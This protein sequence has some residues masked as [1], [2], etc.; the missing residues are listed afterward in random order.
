MNSWKECLKKADKNHPRS[1]D[2]IPELGIVPLPQFTFMQVT[3][4]ETTDFIK[5]HYS[6]TLDDL[7]HGHLYYANQCNSKGKLTANQ[8][9][10][11]LNEHLTYCIYNNILHKH[12]TQL[13]QEGLKQPSSIHPMDHLCIFGVFGSTAHDYMQHYFSHNEKATPFGSGYILALEDNRYIFALPEDEALAAINNIGYNKTYPAEFWTLLDIQSGLFNVEPE[14][15]DKYFLQ[16][17]NQVGVPNTPYYHS[18]YMITG[19]FNE[20]LPAGTLVKKE[21]ENEWFNCGEITASFRFCDDFTLALAMMSSGS[22]TEASH[23]KINN[24][25]IHV[26]P[27]DNY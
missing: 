21:L 20:K 2:I 27:L 8:L 15:S 18:L 7:H 6:L 19:L 16:N 17:F 13:T 10:F 11:Y 25:N 24:T 12:I 14:I 26:L 4:K 1:T 5:Q 23:F 22:E 9:F 3:N